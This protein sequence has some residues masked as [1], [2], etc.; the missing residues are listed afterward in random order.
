[1]KKIIL[2]ILLSICLIT[3]VRE[4]KAQVEIIKSALGL[5]KKASS[6]LSSQDI[7]L[8]QQLYNLIRNSRCLR[9]KLAFYKKF[10]TNNNS[11]AV[12]VDIQN[13][14]TAY[15]DMVSSLGESSAKASDMI[16]K[17]FTST[18][19]GDGSSPDLKTQITNNLKSAN[20]IIKNVEEL[21]G[22]LN[23]SIQ[24]SMDATDFIN[25]SSVSGHEVSAHQTRIL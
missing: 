7:L 24:K 13:T 25:Q 17:L 19:G 2:I 21:N 15:D 11:C 9:L 6:A 1:M 10:I 18:A 22:Y 4:S 8:S 5:F 23:E 14:I 20:E 3:N 12:N 16:S